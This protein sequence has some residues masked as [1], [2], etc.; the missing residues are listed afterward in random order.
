VDTKQALNADPYDIL[1]VA[2]TASQDEIRTAYRTLAKKLHPD[3]NPGNKECEEKFKAASAAYD[4]IGDPEKR[5]RYDNGEI[6]A[7]GA[8]R[9]PRGFYREHAG[10]PQDRYASADGFADIAADDE[11]LAEIFGRRG[12]SKFRMSGADVH[13]RLELGFLDAVNGSKQQITLP[14][15]PALDITI[16]PG[17]RAGQIL[18][19]RGKGMP[20]RNG[21]SPGDA[22]IEVAVRPHPVFAR[23]N[24][25]IRVELAIPLR[26]AVLGGKVDVPTPDGTVSMTVPKWSNS[27]SV[28]RLKGKGVPRRDGGRGDEYVKLSVVLPAKPDAELEQFMSQWQRDG[29]DHSAAATGT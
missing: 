8:E 17:T 9:P 18:R 10:G 6:D 22:L 27:G 26:T 1:G 24:D 28:L 25:D 2:K 5:R 14:D 7:S 13:Y 19:L 4:V 12:G 23:D 21:G 16:P 20:G 3:L 15:G 11:I 29:D